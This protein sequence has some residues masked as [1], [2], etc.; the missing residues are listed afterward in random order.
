VVTITN[1]GTGTL[2][3]KTITR[4][5]TSPTSFR[6]TSDTCSNQGLTHLQSCTVS[7]V[8]APTAAGA[9]S[10]QLWIP[11]ND[12][13]AADNPIKLPLS[14]TGT[15]GG[16]G[17]APDITVTPLS[18]DFGSIAVGATS[19]SQPVTITNSGTANL[20][21]KTIT[22]KGTAPGSFLTS[23]DGCSNT[24]LTPTQ[25]CTV[26][27]AFKPASG[28]LKSAQLSILS[29]DPDV[30]QNPLKV[31]LSGTGTTGGGGSGPKIT[32]TPPSLDFGSI[33]VGSP[34]PPQQ[35]TVT[36]DGDAP[37]KIATVKRTGTFASS[38]VKSSAEDLCTN[39]TLMPGASCTVSVFFKPTSSGLKPAQL[40][41]P[42]N[43]P[44]PA[45]NPV[46]VGLSGSGL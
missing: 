6:T 45:R 26:S 32:V 31:P 12:P 16:G 18:L 33:A 34:T 10:A 42:S 7:V 27:V 25:S 39:K 23:A 30:A 46:L 17:S 2:N 41:I 40:A 22:R 28:G 29:N 3:I 9:K 24:T 38:Y 44:D 21:V 20:L 11:S 14:G 37:L 8:F 36:N 5:G 35:V 19:P 13:D 15:N 4:K 43:D 1:D